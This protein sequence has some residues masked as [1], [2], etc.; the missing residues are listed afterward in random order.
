MAIAPC[1][2]QGEKLTVYIFDLVVRSFVYEMDHYLDS[3]CSETVNQLK[4]GNVWDGDDF[5]N[6]ISVH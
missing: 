2:G 6:Y 5:L 1:E 4:P 3:R